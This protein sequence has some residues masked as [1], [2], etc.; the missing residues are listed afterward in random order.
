MRLPRPRSVGGTETSDGLDLAWPWRPAGPGRAAV[1]VGGGHESLV[2]CCP[3]AV[4]PPA[5][6]TLRF[7]SRSAATKRHAPRVSINQ[8]GQAA[9][10]GGWR[11]VLVW[12]WSTSATTVT[13]T[14]RCGPR[15]HSTCS[16][17]SAYRHRARAE[18]SRCSGHCCPGCTTSPTAGCATSAPVHRTRPGRAAYRAGRTRRQIAATPGADVAAVAS[19]LMGSSG[20]LGAPTSTPNRPTRP[21]PPTCRTDA[22]AGNRALLRSR[23]STR[24][25]PGYGLVVT[26]MRAAR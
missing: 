19:G 24:S 10:E 23:V 4:V 18:T 22:G 3:V 8:L 9:A 25:S 7:V 26:A 16:D 21:K 5:R 14:P 20:E 17:I 15:I 1:E 13:R 12:V 6:S 11:V 2:P